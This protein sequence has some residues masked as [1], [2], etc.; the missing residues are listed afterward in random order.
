MAMKGR[1]SERP[2]AKVS[3]TRAV[4]H[5]ARLEFHAVACS[6]IFPKY[7]RVLQEYMLQ[8]V[9]C[10]CK[11]LHYLWWVARLVFD[12]RTREMPKE[13]YNALTAAGVRQKKVP[14]R[15]AD[16]AGLYLVVSETGAR[17]W[18]WRGTVHG[19]RREIGMGSARLIPLAEAREIAIAWR[20]IAR[21]G[22]DPAEER[23]KG[24]LGKMTFESAAR[25][26]WA[27]QIEPHGRN[28]KHRAQW[29]STLEAYAFPRI[30]SRPV[31]AVTQADIL[32]V[33]APIWTEKPATA[34]RIRQRLKTVMNWARAAGHFAGIN[35]VEGVE[36]GLPKQRAKVR[37]FA[38][39]PYRELPELMRRLEMVEGMGA[40]A[41]RFTILTAARSGEVRGA[42]WSEIDTEVHLW[43]VSG[44][45]MKSGA[46]HRV[47]LSGAA[48]GV[49][50]RVRGLSDG[51]VFPSSWAGRK[52]SDE[53][54]AAALKR[55]DVPV[56]VH[57][58]R[59]T[60]RDWAEEMT[61]FPREVKEAAL[62]HAV[63]NKVEAAY[64]RGDLFDK[65]RDL[66]DR[67]ARFCLSAGSKGDV[68]KLR[69]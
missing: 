3:A 34:R 69:R 62:A 16:G 10:Q 36:D 39:L 51:L 66:M 2:S 31:H 1:A 42:M 41:L 11:P 20:R 43:T 61:G 68:V 35:P 30:G 33:L 44:A 4:D 8:A 48:L 26:V 29:I 63:R 58:M 25:K 53:T 5:S 27:E 38:A 59:S 32:R 46:E 54:L 47:P 28:A 40:L 45:R 65:R 18:Q 7:Q 56:T 37:H 50:D 19:R 52:L 64:R 14:G 13:V 55:L 15:Y 21:A 24:K 6:P 57:G 60:F 49:L 23:D 17:W 67:W 22:G 12:G 9:A